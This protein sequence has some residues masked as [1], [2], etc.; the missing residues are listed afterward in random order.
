M[1]GNKMSNRKMYSNNRE[2]QISHVFLIT[3]PHQV[4]EIICNEWGPILKSA[5]MGIYWNLL[6]KK[7]KE[8]STE[9]S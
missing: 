9:K 8:Q 1:N 3:E 2:R 4:I 5:P 7:G 6:Y